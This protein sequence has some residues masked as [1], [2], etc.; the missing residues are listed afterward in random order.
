MY[1]Y[2]KYGSN[3]VS[4]VLKQPIDLKAINVRVPLLYCMYY[5]G[6][7][8]VMFI[9]NPAGT[10]SNPAETVFISWLKLNYLIFNHLTSTH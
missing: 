3:D 8:A 4:H 7:N 2:L 6:V 9:F 10:I 1:R 5:I